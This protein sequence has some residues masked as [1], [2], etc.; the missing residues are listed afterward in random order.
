MDV[1]LHNHIS[2]TFSEWEDYM[3]VMQENVL[4]LGSCMLRCFG[5]K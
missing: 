2:A 4:P 3:V 1:L 5:E